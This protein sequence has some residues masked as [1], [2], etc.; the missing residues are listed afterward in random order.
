MKYLLLIFGFFTFTF[1]KLLQSDVSSFNVPNLSQTDT[2]YSPSAREIDFPS[3]SGDISIKALFNPEENTVSVEQEIIWKNTSQDSTDRVFLHLYLNAFS[4][5]QTIHVGGRD[6]PERSFTS[7]KFRSVQAAGKSL[8]I[9]YVN[10]DITNLMDS[11]VGVI[12]PGYFIAPGEHISIKLSYS[13]KV[14]IAWSRMGATD[15]GNFI[16]FSQWYPKPGVFKDGRWI[17]SP[18]H[19]YAEFY[20]NFWNFNLEIQYPERYVPFYNGE[21]QLLNSREKGWKILRVKAE[22]RLDVVFGFYTQFEDVKFTI[23]NTIKG[24]IV[25]PKYCSSFIE[26]YK[27]IIEGS[28]SYLGKMLGEYPYKD[29]TMVVC[30][31]NSGGIASMEYPGLITI[32]HK[33]FSPEYTQLPEKLIAHE[34]VHQF[35]YGSVALNETYEAWIDEGLAN[36]LSGRIMDEF[37][38]NRTSFFYLFNI[39]PVRGLS[40]VE[41]AD[42]PLIYTLANIHIPNETESLLNYYNF[43]RAGALSDSSYLF[44]TYYEYTTVSYGKGELFFLSLEKLFGKKQFTN[45]LGALYK[46]YKLKHMSGENLL[47]F[48]KAELSTLNDRYIESLYNHTEGCDYQILSIQQDTLSATCAV[49]IRREGDVRYP[50]VLR[51]YT[52]TD[53]LLK[54]VTGEKRDMRI[55]FNNVNTEVSG[56]EIDPERK[57]IFDT[58]FANN[59]LVLE[60]HYS[61]G[62][63]FSIRWLFW[64][65]SFFL[66]FG[67]IA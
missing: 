49:R 18:Y 17:C 14:P 48:I 58:N 39:Y 22:N 9:Q 12:K 1:L 51:L 38:S 11:T 46:K 63:Y 44:E 4:N 16:F 60:P 54:S 62:I 13:F 66:I 3:N 52:A 37:F 31:K 26:R 43:N 47:N 15:D 34:I 21:G 45:L 2:A 41:L 10:T 55:V 8:E 50:A 59:S 27:R 28:F 23:N 19:K 33:F 53:T 64:M 25:Y 20:S 40:L 67:A 32:Q 65:Q 7:I 35:F 36:Y 56:A 6:L 5:R 61:A 29:F 24:R 30:P 42:L 57:N